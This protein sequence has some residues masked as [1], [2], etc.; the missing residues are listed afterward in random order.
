MKPGAAIVFFGLL[1]FCGLAAAAVAWTAPAIEAKL[2][3]RAAEQL[4]DR[5]LTFARIDADGRDLIVT[6]AA[7]DPKKR[8]EA[9]R[10]VAST[11]GSRVG[12]D[13]MTVAAPPPPAP[14]PAVDTSTLALAKKR[15]AQ[16]QADVDD[17][18][19]GVA[20]FKRGSSQVSSEGKEVIAD[21]AVVLE[22]C[23]DGRFEIEGH[24]DASGD[25]GF[26]QIISEHRA[27]AVK[28]ALARRGIPQSR[29]KATGYGS[30]RPIASNDD[31]EG[32]VR[33]R[34]IELQVLRKD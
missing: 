18:I 22:R 7:P 13:R 9:I 34:R 28:R 24:T 15:F 2:T 8:E 33:N 29:M 16:C 26:N 3:D 14:P 23:A 1:A 27:R 31:P 20:F 21:V 19:A 30:R 6:G 5:N 4:A 11:W 17:L 25:E 32:R 10:I 12:W